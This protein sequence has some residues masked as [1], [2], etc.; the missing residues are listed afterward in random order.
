MSNLY[1]LYPT[2]WNDGDGQCQQALTVY[3]VDCGIAKPLF[4][5]ACSRRPSEDPAYSWAAPT[6][7]RI[8]PPSPPGGLGSPGNYGALTSVGWS[9]LIGWIQ[10][11]APLGYVIQGDLSRLK[12]Y[13]DVYILGP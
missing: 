7:Q 9:G 10:S 8:L 1:R 3:A 5:T 6:F 2:L 11:V 13:S 12:A 4:P